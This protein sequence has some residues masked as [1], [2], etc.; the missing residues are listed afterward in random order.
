MI[1]GNLAQMLNDLIAV[2]RETVSDGD[3]IA[4]YMAFG[5]ITVSGK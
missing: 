3:G 4:P 1:S 5:G 2:S